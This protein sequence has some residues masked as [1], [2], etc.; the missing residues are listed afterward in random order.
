MIVEQVLVRCIQPVDS[1]CSLLHNFVGVVLRVEYDGIGLDAVP[2]FCTS[3]ILDQIYPL[4]TVRDWLVLM[5]VPLGHLYFLTIWQIH[6]HTQLIVKIIEDDDSGSGAAN[7]KNFLRPSWVCIHQF[8]Q[9][10]TKLAGSLNGLVLPQVPTSFTYFQVLG[11]VILHEDILM[12]RYSS[13]LKSHVYKHPF[14]QTY[15]SLGI[16]IPVDFRILRE[17]RVNYMFI[18]E[19]RTIFIESVSDEHRNIICPA[20]TGSGTK[21]NPF[22]FF[23]NF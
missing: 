22:I 17:S 6:E 15:Q 8:P 1:A 5:A 16:Q 9:Q 20:V 11:L 7:I 12:V 10:I 3:I 14:T 19:L 4:L 13:P 21:Q 23:R 2:T 18:F